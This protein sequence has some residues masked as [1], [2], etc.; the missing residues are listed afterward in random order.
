MS[1]LSYETTI[2]QIAEYLLKL[3]VGLIEHWQRE[4]KF[5]PFKTFC[6]YRKLLVFTGTTMMVL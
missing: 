1:Y 4:F 5:I 2:H 6:F 3:L